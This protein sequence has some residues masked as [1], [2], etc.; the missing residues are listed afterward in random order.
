MKPRIASVLHA[1]LAEFSITRRLVRF[2]I[3]VAVAAICLVIAYIASCIVLVYAAPTDLHFVSLTP[4]HLFSNIDP[5]LFLAL[6]GGLLLIVF[7]ASHRHVRDRTDEV[8]DSRPLSNFESLCGRV[9][10]VVVLIWLSISLLILGLQ[11]FGV[12][13]QVF[14]FGFA[15]PMQAHSLVNLLL[16]DIPVT[17]LFWTAVVVFL[18]SFLRARLLVLA[19]SS[20]AMVVFYFVASRTPFSLLSLVS[21]SANASLFISDVVP[22][23][24][25]WQSVATRVSGVLISF[26]L[27]STASALVKRRDSASLRSTLMS[28]VVLALLGA[29]SYVLAVAGVTS[30]QETVAGWRDS[31]DAIEWEHN[32]DVQ[33]MAGKIAI[34]PGRALEIELQLSVIVKDLPTDELTFTFN[35]GMEIH[36]IE[37]DTRETNYT[38]SNGLLR[39]RPE[40]PLSVDSQHVLRIHAAGVPNPKFAYFNSAVDYQTDV[41]FDA[42]LV[43]LFGTDG[44]IYD[45]NFV[46]LMPGSFWYPIPGPVRSNDVAGQSGTDYFNV[47]LLVDLANPNWNLVASA[48]TSKVGDRLF[49]LDTTSPIAQLGLLTSAFR[50][51]AIDVDGVEFALFVHESHR[52]ALEVSY[53]L[54]RSIRSEIKSLLDPLAD[55]GL[56]LPQDFLYFVEVPSRLRTVGGGWRMDTADVLPGVVLL[57]EHALPTSPFHSILEEPLTWGLPENEVAGSQVRN[58]FLLLQYS[59]GTDNPWSGFPHRFFNQLTSARGEHAATLDQVVNT[60]LS[61]LTLTWDFFSIHSTLYVAHMASFNPVSSYIVSDLSSYSSG[62]MHQLQRLGDLEEKYGQRPLVWEQVERR[63]LASIPSKSGNQADVEHLLFMSARI[64]DGLLAL[65]GRTKVLTWLADLRNTFAGHSY[66]YADLLAHA[67]S[68]EVVVDPFLTEWL[69]SKDVPGY[70]VSKATINRISDDEQGNERYQ[71]CFDIR[72]VQ[73]VSGY[74][75]VLYSATRPFHNS[76]GA[77]IGANSSCRFCFVSSV[78]P[79]YAHVRT[80]L[81]LNRGIE[82]IQD[83]ANMDVGEVDTAPHPVVT[84]SDWVPVAEGIVVDDLDPGFSVAQVNPR[85]KRSMLRL[86]GLSMFENRLEVE[87]DYGLPTWSWHSED[88]MSNTWQRRESST[89][90]GKFRKTYAA[91]WVRRNVAKATFSADLPS[92]GHWQLE[93]HIPDYYFGSNES[94]YSMVLTDTLRS[95]EFEVPTGDLSTGWNP[96]DVFQLEQGTVDLKLVDVSKSSSAYADAIRWTQV[97]A[98]TRSAKN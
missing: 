90:Y 86:G 10:G 44:S 97:D 12:I 46:A 3:L 11:G 33:D 95:I 57:K 5:L 78:P 87:L 59:I 40:E 91:A 53:D 92:T 54:E 52:R 29:C 94:I 96:I 42:H 89:A 21:P 8:V 26:V 49:R 2:R 14:D 60:I 30:Q 34:D 61:Q 66:T 32:F 43:K 73:P 72:N 31:H 24:A 39:I 80:G 98:E 27:I 63:S 85:Y 16:L 77:V 50:K 69:T 75:A 6:Q 84:E 13:A 68:H 25:S 4:Q 23:L 47:D 56:T 45:R 82:L 38:F 51:A 76:Y 70:F 65:N 81:S 35:P 48:T 28:S 9:I 71:T 83:G 41:R 7:D 64:A 88:R 37:L 15:E 55:I 19:C 93:Y 74:V 22:E 36:A 62:P 79:T 17:L 18:S 58:L 67:K 20:I 1:A